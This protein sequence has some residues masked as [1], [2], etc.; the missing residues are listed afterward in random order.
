MQNAEFKT[1]NAECKILNNSLFQIEK[2]ATDYRVALMEERASS[3]RYDERTS[4]PLAQ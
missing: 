1:Q 3:A 4:G 2:D